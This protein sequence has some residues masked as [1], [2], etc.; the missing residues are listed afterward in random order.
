LSRKRIVHLQVLPILSGVQKISLNIFKNLDPDKF[1][2]YLICAAPETGMDPLLITES[3]AAGVKVIVLK[4]LKREIGFHD[5]SVFIKLIKIFRRYRFN[6]IHTHSSKTGFLGRIAGKLSGCGAAVIHTAHGIP[7]HKFE[8]PV[9]RIF[10]IFLEMIAGLCNDKIVLVNKYYRKKF[11]FIPSRK[12]MTIYNSIDLSDY[13]TKKKRSDNKTR[14]ISVGRLDDQK[15]PMDLLEAMKLISQDRTDISISIIG[16]GKYYAL[17]E[18]YIK[19]YNLQDKVNLL[20]WR[21]DIPNLLSEHDIFVSSPIY[22]AFGLVFCEAGYAGLPVIS[23]NV[24]GIPEVVDDGV[25][26][27][28][29]PPRDPEALAKAMLFLTDNKKLAEEMGEKAK[30]RVRENFDLPRFIEEYTKLYELY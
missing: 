8:T 10:Y 22:E 1:E 16:D 23:T 13:Q 25:T 18:D 27:I 6:I 21:T 11:W 20:G 7:F 12:L 4:E 17:I 28:L 5:I 30:I 29:V 19:K 26:G 2:L 14:F 9:K 15:S 24:E 3:E